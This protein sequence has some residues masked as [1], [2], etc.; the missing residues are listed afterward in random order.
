MTRSRILMLAILPSVAYAGTVFESGVFATAEDI[1][2]TTVLLTPGATLTLQT[3]GFG[4]GV[5]LTGTPVSSGGFDPLVAVFMGSGGSAT[6]VDGTSDGLSNYGGLAGCPPA[7]TRD[8]GAFTGQC[9]DI[10]MTFIGLSPGIYTVLLNDA[11]YIP[12]ALFD[13]GPAP[14]LD[15]GF[16]DLTGGSLP[17]QTCVDLSNCVTDTAAWAL[18]VTVSGPSTSAPEPA[19]SGILGLGLLVF[20]NYKRNKR[21]DRL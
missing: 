20:I 3:Y 1:F 10:S 15:E 16:T 8:I 13:P 4:G 14:T 12:N 9:G 2:Q 21:R 18:D 5:S 6:L 19:D 17:F 11:E 7:S